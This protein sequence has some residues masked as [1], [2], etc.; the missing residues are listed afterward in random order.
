M[1]KLRK[2]LHD[3]QLQRAAASVIHAEI[4]ATHLAISRAE[5]GRHRSR[6]REGLVR[7]ARERNVPP[8][9]PGSCAAVRSSGRFRSLVLSNCTDPRFA[10]RTLISADLRAALSFVEAASVGG[11]TVPFDHQ[12]HRQ[13]HASY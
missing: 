13:R 4:G 6:D 11:L 3:E 8:V 9:H 10:V 12:I 2:S 7:D 5:Q 1:E